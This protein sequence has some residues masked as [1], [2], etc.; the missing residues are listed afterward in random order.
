MADNPV[1]ADMQSVMEAIAALT[2][3]ITA[4]TAQ[5]QTLAAA[6]ENNATVTPTASTFAMTLDQLKVEDIIDYSDKVDL[7]LW[8]A[9][10]EAL[11]NKFDMKA[12]GM[13]IFVE[14]MKAKAQ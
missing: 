14:G 13:M 8:K 11:P 1:S 3:Q 2:A 6:V 9:A 10:I 4:I 12:I 7:S 5:V